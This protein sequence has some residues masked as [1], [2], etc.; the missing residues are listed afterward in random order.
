MFSVWP[1]YPREIC[2]N[3]E[4][5]RYFCRCRFAYCLFRCRRLCSGP[6]GAGADAAADAAAM[7]DRHCNRRPWRAVFAPQP[8]MF[9]LAV[10]NAEPTVRPF[11][12]WSVSAGSIAAGQGTPT[13]RVDTT[14]AGSYGSITATVF[15]TGFNP[16][17]YV[18]G[19]ATVEVKVRPVG[20]EA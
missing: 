5:R 18:S 12:S 13:I 4:N 20:E 3:E 1:D 6:A 7:S 14:D 11:Y 19:N 2:E 8:I 15:V 17:C 10:A 9:T 16:S